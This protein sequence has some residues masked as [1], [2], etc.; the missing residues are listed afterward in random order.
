MLAVKLQNLSH[1]LGTISVF[2]VAQNGR[3]VNVKRTREH[4]CL[5]S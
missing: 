4:L 3:G 2:F 1:P 5:C